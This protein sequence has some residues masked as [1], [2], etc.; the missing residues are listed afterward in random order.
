MEERYQKTVD[1]VMKELGPDAFM[2]W[3]NCGA[4]EENLRPRIE[5]AEYAFRSGFKDFYFAVLQPPVNKLL[6]QTDDSAAMEIG[7]GSGRLIHAAAH[8]FKEVIGVD[9]HTHEEFV[10]ELLKSKGVNNVVLHR[11]DGKTLPVN[12]ESVDFVYSIIVFIHLSSPQILE[13]YLSETYR[14][15]KKSGVASFY[16]GKPYSYRTRMSKNKIMSAIYSFAELIAEVLLLD[17]FG[18]GYRIF[19]DVQANE[20]SLMVTRLKMRQLAKKFGFRVVTQKSK[21]SWSQRLVVLQKV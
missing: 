21:K 7:Y 4:G 3:F 10:L 6:G 19:P 15:L 20:V 14:V 16:Y 11:T 18:D 9:I 5:D 12:D 13:G 2:C 1:R 17:L 8:L